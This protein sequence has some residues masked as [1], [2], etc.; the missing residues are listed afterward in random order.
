MP[1]A[2]TAR[3]D[4]Y[5][6]GSVYLAVLLSDGTVEL[7]CDGTRIARARWDGSRIR[8]R[9]RA[10]PREVLDD[11]SERLWIYVS[12]KDERLLYHY[13]RIAG[14][15]S[16]AP[17]VEEVARTIVT[18]EVYFSDPTTFN[19]V[20]DCTFELDYGSSWQDR[21]RFL[22]GF[23]EA[24][25]LAPEEYR[26]QV[27]WGKT[28]DRLRDP[29]FM[30]N[31]RAAV[32]RDFK[33]AGVFCLAPAWDEEYMWESYG[34]GGAGVCLTFG[35][36]AIGDKPN[37]VLKVSY[38]ESRAVSLYAPKGEIVEAVF[39]SKGLRWKKEREHRCVHY[40]PD[41]GARRMHGWFPMSD[42]AV[43]EVTFGEHADAGLERPL[44]VAARHAPRSVQVY[45][46]GRSED[47]RIV[48][49]LVSTP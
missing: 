35:F 40:D 33:T 27:R 41:W 11:L 14:D 46:A 48:R 44:I 19:D 29:D 32:E 10:L 18:G 15:R 25:H 31:V 20:N 23:L 17:R 34:D 3:I 39:A 43:R 1:A 12:A 38:V 5:H 37:A 47:G 13:R 36:P 4:C 45:R 30:D 42:Y 49:R 6:R 22:R 21:D 2:V 16:G 28:T 7:T 24:Q 8:T 9:T 26:L